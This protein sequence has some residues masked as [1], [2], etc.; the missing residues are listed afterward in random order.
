MP[1]P[2]ALPEPGKP[3]GPKNKAGKE[4]DIRFTVNAFVLEGVKVLPQ[5]QVQ[6]ILKPWVGK[7]VDF[8]DLQNA[9]NAIMDFYRSKGFTVQAILP[10]QKIAGGIV[11][12][13][14]TE[15]TLSSVIIESPQGDTRFGKER[16]A[17]YIAYNN[18]IGEPL[19][20]DNL[21]HAL[22]ILNETPGVMI[23]S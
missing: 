12:I 20:L 3:I 19:N 23:S 18:R 11:K 14:I 6:E 9:C 15:A 5:E 8:D 22:I 13:L 1:S 2:L 10:P 17:K 21:E 16:A 4:G 7:P